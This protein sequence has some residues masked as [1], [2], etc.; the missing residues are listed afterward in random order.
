YAAPLPV[1]VPVRLAP[2]LTLFPYTTL[3]RS[4]KR[5]GQRVGVVTRRIHAQKPVSARNRRPNLPAYV[6]AAA[7]ASRYP[8]HRHRRIGIRERSQPH[9]SELQ[10]RRDRSCRLA[11]EENTDIL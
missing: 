3:F 1:C 6:N 7:V 10:P 8:R 5:L 11:L 4:V 2:R 9:T